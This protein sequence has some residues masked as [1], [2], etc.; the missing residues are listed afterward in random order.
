MD[1]E[2][3]S[4]AAPESL[5]TEREGEAYHVEGTGYDFIPTVLDRDCIDRLVIF[6]LYYLI[7]GGKTP[8]IISVRLFKAWGD[9]ILNLKLADVKIVRK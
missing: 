4:L 5:N 1:P 8:F 3:S 6:F 7:V 2:G 9:A